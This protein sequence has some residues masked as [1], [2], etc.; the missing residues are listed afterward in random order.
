MNIKTRLE[1]LEKTEQIQAR[2]SWFDF[3]TGAWEPDPDEWRAFLEA[4]TNEYKAAQ[5]K[6]TPA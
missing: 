3:I 5:A 4:R 1:Q 2:P 6:N